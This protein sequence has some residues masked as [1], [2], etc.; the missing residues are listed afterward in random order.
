MSEPALDIDFPLWAVLT[1]IGVSVSLMLTFVA[2]CSVRCFRPENEKGPAWFPSKEG[3]EQ[4]ARGLFQ[5]PDGK[6]GFVRALEGGAGA[7]AV[8]TAAQ[9]R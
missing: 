4:F 2:C 9:L 6:S 7:G 1:I 5:E 8:G 3:K